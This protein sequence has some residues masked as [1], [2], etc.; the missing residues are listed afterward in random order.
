MAIQQKKWITNIN[1]IQ[2]QGL[3]LHLIEFIP[4][5]FFQGRRFQFGIQSENFIT[6][7]IEIFSFFQI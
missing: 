7:P 6:H 1:T 3:I 2:F 5:K 4:C